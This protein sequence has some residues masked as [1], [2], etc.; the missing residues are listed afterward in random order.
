MEFKGAGLYF[1]RRQNGRKIPGSKA[2]PSLPEPGVNSERTQKLLKTCG[3]E[4]S[5]TQNYQNESSHQYLPHVD[6]TADVTVINNISRTV[7]TQYFINNT[8]HLIKRASYFFPLYHYSAITAFRFRN[9]TGNVEGVLRSKKN[10]RQAFERATQNE[11]AASL[12]EQQTPEIFETV[13]GNMQPG[14]GLEVEIH[15]TTELQVDLSGEGLLLTIPSSIAPRFGTP[16]PTY[17]VGLDSSTRL[18]LSNGLKI[19][20]DISM[21]NPISNLNSRAHPT[22]VTMGANALKTPVAAFG[23]LAKPPR[24]KRHDTTKARVVLSSQESTLDQD[25]V[26]L[27]ATTSDDNDN[28]EEGMTNALSPRALVES[29]PQYQ[30]LSA[31]QVSFTPRDLFALRQYPP[32]SNLE[33]VLLVDLSGSMHSKLE[34]LKRALVVFL[35]NL[36]DDCLFNICIFG[37]SFDSMWRESKRINESNLACALQYIAQLEADKG[38]TNLRSAL[39]TAAGKTRHAFATQVVVFTDGEVWDVKEVND[40]VVSAKTRYGDALRFFALGI[41]DEVSHELIE[42]IGRYGGGFSEVIAVESSEEWDD[43]VKRLL[44]GVRTPSDWK[45]E[46]SLQD[47]EGSFHSRSG[48]SLH[49]EN[50]IIGSGKIIQAP[51]HIPVVHGFTYTTVYMLIDAPVDHYKTV[52][53]TALANEGDHHSTTLQLLRVSAQ[54]PAFHQFAAK[55][56]LSDLE[57]S[58]SWLH[59][60]KYRASAR[61]TMQEADS[62][63]EHIAMLWGLASKWTSFV[64]ISD[65]DQTEHASRLH[66]AGYNR[67]EIQEL[68]RPRKKDLSVSLNGKR[69]NDYDGR[70][71]QNPGPGPGGSGAGSNAGRSAERFSSGATGNSGAGSGRREEGQGKG[72]HTSTSGSTRAQG[73]TN[74]NSQTP[75]SL[76]QISALQGADGAFHF[77][78]T[79]SLDGPPVFTGIMNCFKIGVMVKL[80]SRTSGLIATASLRILFCKAVLCI[81]YIKRTF[82]PSSQR[83]SMVKRAEHFLQCAV[84]PQAQRKQFVTEVERNWAH[85]SESS[86]TSPYLLEIDD[87]ANIDDAA[88]NDNHGNSEGSEILQSSEIPSDTQFPR[89][90]PGMTP[91]KDLP[92]HDRDRLRVHELPGENPS[93]PSPRYQPTTTSR[94]RLDP[95]GSYPSNPRSDP[96][97]RS[98]APSSH[99]FV[100]PAPRPEPG[101]YIASDGRMYPLRQ[102]PN[103]NLP[104]D[105]GINRTRHGGL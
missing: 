26:L 8:E 24:K 34:C 30:G 40:Y 72:T 47:R 53:I 95:Y 11:L 96:Y 91:L 85:V 32:K 75:I 65:V 23:D 15:Y 9:N 21:P 38:G 83:S 22:K 86:G 35:S 7:L 63:A 44:D 18:K 52:Q 78:E 6:A 2:K 51:H 70:G 46:L 25:F 10:A 71:G 48:F 59:D 57:M 98:S 16:P 94:E 13:V 56:L 77:D 29:C 43:R 55:A 64:G 54:Q 102:G 69:S 68:M 90:P 58:Y 33:V 1:E 12:L 41:G 42:G 61:M 84:E 105:L 27:I 93:I 103:P 20:V 45:I 31:L 79:L 28:D 104:N 66:H 73:G 60:E 62:E 5:Q 97:G 82:P 76:E 14:H 88:Q 80:V 19:Q 37:T 67:R 99:T 3:L 100:T 101:Y 74:D 81:E 4:A 49:E 87:S 39:H 89:E 50:G 36:H 17:S 92:V